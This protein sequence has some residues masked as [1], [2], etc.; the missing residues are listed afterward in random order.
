MA[1]SRYRASINGFWCHNETWDDALN[2]DGKHDEVFIAVNTKVVDTNGTILQNFDSEGA[3]MGDTWSISG[4]VQAGSASDRGGIVSN[5]KYPSQTP[6]K[7]LSGMLNEGVRAPPYKIWEGDLKPGEDLV[8]L[9]PTIWEW[10]PGT[11]FWDGWLAWQ[12][13]VDA[14]YGQRAKDIFGGIWPVAAPVFD[15]VSLGIQTVGTLAGLWSP[16]GQSMRR[17]IGIRRDPNDP[18]NFLFNPRTIALNCE[19]AEYLVNHDL[20]GLGNGVVELLYS[21]DPYLRGVYSIYVQIDQLSSGHAEWTDVGHANNVVGMTALDGRL[22]CATADNQLWMRDAVHTEVD[23]IRIGHAN[24][25]VGLAALGGRLFCATADNRLWSRDA[26]PRE[27]DWTEIGHANGISDMT[28]LDGNLFCATNDNGLW[29]RQPLL[30]NLNW[31]RIG[32]ANGA[33]AMAAAPGSLYCANVNGL[34]RRDPVMT[35][36]GWQ[37]IGTAPDIRALAA[38]NGELFAATGGNRLLVRQ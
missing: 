38:V 32:N 13:E 24:N 22:F 21:D 10:D 1:V 14:K 16:L 12:V 26:L 27:I 30:R 34:Y 36:V 15:A 5:D 35:D 9:T 23:W 18:N 17:P 33:I 25:V 28:A 2:W 4:R 37:Q 8:L 7:N 3:V 19:T 29:V 31:T 6:W 20:Q 11:G